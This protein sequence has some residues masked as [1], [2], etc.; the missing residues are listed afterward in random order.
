MPFKSEAQ[1]KWMYANEPKMAARW[2]EETPRNKKFPKKVANP[3]YAEG[4]REI[5][6]SNK[7]GVHDNRPNRKRSRSDALRKSIERSKGEH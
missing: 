4:M 7:A 1:R 2:E 5:R 6:K 3:A